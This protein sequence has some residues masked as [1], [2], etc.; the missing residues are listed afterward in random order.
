[1]SVFQQKKNFIEWKLKDSQKYDFLANFRD[2]LWVLWARNLCTLY[3]TFRNST[4]QVNQ[5][6]LMRK[7]AFCLRNFWKMAENGWKRL[8]MACYGLIRYFFFGLEGCD[9]CIT[10]PSCPGH[11]FNKWLKLS[12]RKVKKPRNLAS[13]YY[14]EF[15]KH[16]RETL[17]STSSTISYSII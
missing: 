17:S 12:G 11:M 8:K 3:Y 16:N 13:P 14:C 4:I 10:S 7:I 9:G 6:Q 1:M 2:F 15:F 5:I